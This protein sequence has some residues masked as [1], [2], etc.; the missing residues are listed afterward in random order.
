MPPIQRRA[1]SRARL[2]SSRLE[3]A[4]VVDLRSDHFTVDNIAERLKHL[5]QDP[6]KTYFTTRQHVTKNMVRRLGE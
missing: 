2:G 4:V 6:W 3:G 5:R 1:A